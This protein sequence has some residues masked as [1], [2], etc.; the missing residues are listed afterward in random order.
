MNNRILLQTKALLRESKLEKMRASYVSYSNDWDARK[1]CREYELRIK[2]TQKKNRDATWVNEVYAIRD[3]RLS[4]AAAKYF[5]IGNI[6]TD[7]IKEAD[8]IVAQKVAD[9][10]A[11]ARELDTQFDSFL[12]TLTNEQIAAARA[13][14]RKYN[15]T[16]SEVLEMCQRATRAEMKAFGPRLDRN[17]KENALRAK[18]TELDARFESLTPVK[19]D[20]TFFSLADAILAEVNSTSSD[21]LRFCK[22]ASLKAAKKIAETIQAEKIYLEGENKIEQLAAAKTHTTQ[23]CQRAWTVYNEL[24]SNFSHYRNALLLNECVQEAKRINNEII[25]A[26][27]VKALDPKSDF[28]TV[29]ALDAGLASFASRSELDQGIPSFQSKWKKRVE[30]AVAESRKKADEYYAQALQLYYNQ[31]YDQAYSLFIESDKYGNKAAAEKIG[32]HYYYGRGV[33]AN[34]NTAKSY[35]Q[36]AAENGNGTA[37][38]HLADIFAKERNHSTAFIWRRQAVSAINAAGDRMELAK[39]YYEGKGTGTSYIEARKLFESLKNEAGFKEEANAYLGKIYENALGVTKDEALALEHYRQ[40]IGIEWAKKEFDRLNEKLDGERRDR[41]I[42]ENLERAKA[43]N[44]YSQYFIGWC[45]YHGYRTQRSYEMAKIWF[46]KAAAQ[47]YGKAMSLLGDMYANG[48]GVPVDY[49]KAKKY[50]SDARQ[51]GE[52]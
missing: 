3:T 38:S 1:E 42:L 17:E 20:K 34:V 25:C 40:A 6:L 47:G 43:G 46:E 26:P 48:Y 28:K 45:Y 13:F 19:R 14:L 23:W 51:H 29:L 33:S 12:G 31:K 49:I 4:S 32:E 8:A 5:L 21:I 18:A 50:Y 52:A 7:M 15:N 36:K 35:F 11:K 2:D 10:R 41:E 39:M 30:Q 24:L 16:P 9:C 22:S 44:A 37:M 27:Y